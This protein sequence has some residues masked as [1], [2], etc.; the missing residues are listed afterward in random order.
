MNF[1]SHILLALSC[2][3]GIVV[4]GQN[5]EFIEN[6][7]QWD[8][9]VSFMGQVTNGNFFIH[10]NGYTVLQ[11]NA[12]DWH[13]MNE[14]IHGKSSSKPVVLRSHAYRVD[15]QGANTKASIV[16]DKPVFSYNNYFIGDDPSKWAANCRIYQ[17]ITIKDIYPNID[18]RYYTD[19]GTLKYDLVVHPGG[20]V[21]DIALKY[22]GVDELKVK[23][24]ELVI[25]TSLGELKERYPYTYQ[26]GEKGR[27]EIGA[28]Y[29][30][31][32]N[33]VKFDVKQYDPSAILVI[34][35]TLE[36]CSFSGSSAENWGYTATY[37]PDGSMFGGGIVRGSGF[38]VNTGAF[39][40]TFAG[41][42]EDIGIIK[43]SPDGSTRLYA[44]Y[45]G[46]SAIEQPHS[47]VVDAQGNLVIAGR[48]NSDNY[49]VVGPQ[50]N[51]G[52][53]FDI[54]VT[55]LNA[56]GNAIIG[57]QRIGGRSDDGA[58]IRNDHSGSAT[59]LLRNYG[60]DGRSEVILDGAGNIYV[61]SCT[62]S[63]N[64]PVRNGFQGT[65]GGGQDAVVLKLSPDV[66]NL[67]FSTYLGGGGN[68]AGYVLSLAPNGNIYVAG[69]TESNSTGAQPFPGSTAGT[70]GPV[71][72][73]GIDGFISIIS[74][75]GSAILR[76]TFVGTSAIDQIYGIQFD[77]LGFPYIM[78][79]T[80][81]T[82]SVINATWSQA[83]GKQFIA[84][85][86]PD[87]SAYVYRT[88][89]GKGETAPDIS[90]VAFLVD[91]CENV[92]V[93]GWGG[94]VSGNGF[95]T[96]G[97]QGLP[98]TPD[99]IKSTPDINPTTGIGEDFYFFVLQKNATAILYGSF[100]GQNSA[101][102]G[103]HVDGGTSRF[104]SEGVIYQAICAS[105]SNNNPFPTT[106]GAFAVTKPTSANCNLAMVKIAFNLAGVGSSVQSLI[107]GVPRDTAG[108]VPL[109]V[110]FIDTIGQ[111]QF[112]EWDFGDNTG[113][114]V[115]NTPNTSHT[116][117]SVGV[118]Q[119]MLV[120]VDS[121]SCNIRD[122]SYMNIKVGASQALP[123]F[124][125]NKIGPCT[126][127]QYRFD[128]T[129]VAP[130]GFPFGPQSFIWDFGDNTPRVVSGPGSITHTF[131][132]P[133]TYNVRLILNDDTYCNS[134]DS[135]V[136][137]LRVAAFVS[138]EFDTEPTGCA[139][140]N[141]VFTNN[142]SG[143]SQFIWD[144]GDGSQP[145]NEVNPT[146]LYNNPGTYTITLI[147]IDSATCNISDTVRFTVSVLGNPVADFTASPQPPVVNTAI[148]F[149]NLSSPD[150][151]RFKWLFGDGDSLITTSRNVVQHEYNSTGTFNVCL[152][153]TN[154]AGCP[155]TVCKEVNTIIEPAVDV[156]TAFTPLNGGINSIVFVRGFGIARMKFTVW[157][158]WGE[159]VFET[160]SKDIGWDGRYKGKLLPM[161]VY[162]YTLDVEF[163]DGTKTTK[164]GD[165]TLIR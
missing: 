4:F 127:F 28:K 157:A 107:G 93:S 151:I 41:G 126:E 135:L 35:P 32:G 31:K 128:N 110:D 123:D 103:D 113:Q 39:Q 144:F 97:V 79:Q 46:G 133:G 24:K 53:A 140:Y 115:T 50:P 104:N 78:G 1:K 7:G 51:R 100:F 148:S 114:I 27:T 95:P 6:K 8:K 16:A 139:P 155:D 73:G 49:P 119:V 158:R 125:A 65:L 45:I 154:Q 122:T 5:I 161:D 71:S 23:N 55:K 30:V 87:L 120:A 164:K 62:Q 134:P 74:N 64:F 14:Q 90:P 85:L 59:S 92:Y 21:A 15:F 165:I 146:H 38:P 116:Y 138:A 80:T 36:F 3:L 131:A 47:L 19:K 75:N 68:D 102:L 132:S 91:R 26:Y 86:Q 147:A 145:S 142:S 141:A 52:T 152:I 150:A 9:S 108:C 112:Y 43:L 72:N 63:D 117:T 10:P 159:K 153:A 70:L 37:G 124:T 136:K 149:T 29:S 44:T 84:K 54:V 143:G 98:V 69:G 42:V 105:C 22:T 13:E 99:A 48:S 66:S 18:L 2:L 156:P 25:G 61:A 58:N 111:A 101:V 81:G 129:S 76:T 121:A 57:S 56:A 94:R 137:Q 160:N 34:D 163:S 67:L 88:T 162:A 89:F 40:Q 60:D 106:P 12:E 82:M 20:S 77:R 118:F 109:T 17:G 96:A 130:A 33:T 11:Y 83:N